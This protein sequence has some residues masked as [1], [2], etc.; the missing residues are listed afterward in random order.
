MLRPRL[1]FANVAAS[2][3]LFIALG[4]TGYAALSLPK[5]SVGNLQLKAG[6]VNSA[7]VADGS[8]KAVD[9]SKDQLPT[10][11]AGPA[12][13]PGSQGPVGAPGTNGQNGTNGSNGTNGAPGQTGPFPDTLP[14][15]KT[16]RG[17]WALAGTASGADFTSISWVWPLATAPA[18][19]LAPAGGPNPAG[20]S[21]TPAEPTADEGYLCVYVGVQSLNASFANLTFANPASGI[22]AAARQGIVLSSNG[23]GGTG[24][25]WSTYG[26]WAVTGS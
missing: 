15:G 3:A 8:L 18:V 13:P 24:T 9:F 12:G 6:A 20:C 10:G 25:S 4:G 26:S 7:K 17:T 11:V 14:T 19:V 16:I 23:T 2:A 1:T 21:G 5:N 22:G